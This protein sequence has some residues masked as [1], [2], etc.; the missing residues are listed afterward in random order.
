MT[1]A[2]AEEELEE[3]D[4]VDRLEL[5]A[6]GARLLEASL[7]RAISSFFN[8]RVSMLSSSFSSSSSIS[9]ELSLLLSSEISMGSA[10]SGGGGGGGGRCGS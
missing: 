6:G 5:K 2:C 8:R 9:L 1:I 10:T 3:D 4:T 7:R